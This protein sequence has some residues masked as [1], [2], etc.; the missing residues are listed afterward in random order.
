MEKLFHLDA[1][2]GVAEEV[3]EAPP[4][5]PAPDDG[6]AGKTEGR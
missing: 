3:A 5:G 1:A 2:E 4:A 6:A